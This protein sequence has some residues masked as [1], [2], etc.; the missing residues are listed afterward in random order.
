MT[1]RKKE[2]QRIVEDNYALAKRLSEST[3]GVS[4]KRFDDEWQNTTKYMNSISKRNIRK[5]PKL[6]EL[7]KFMHSVPSSDIGSKKVISLKSPAPETYK[8][9][10][11]P[12]FNSS[13]PGSVLEVANEDKD[14]PKASQGLLKKE[15]VHGN[16]GKGVNEKDFSEIKFQNKI[17]EKDKS[18][19]KSG[20]KDEEEKN[21]RSFN[22]RNQDSRLRPEKSSEKVEGFHEISENERNYQL[23]E[24]KGKKS[25]NKL[26]QIEKSQEINLKKHDEDEKQKEGEGKDIKINE[27]NEEDKGEHEK[28][29]AKIEKTEGKHNKKE[30]KG[31]DIHE[32]SKENIKEI[33]LDNEENSLEPVIEVQKPPE[34]VI[35]DDPPENSELPEAELSVVP[36]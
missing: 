4:F 10:F 31:E 35:S 25:E 21:G 29:V 9:S 1:S 6:E 22:G 26:Q 5:L 18:F 2:A 34:A 20:M 13:L 24:K 23:E 27:G 7:N 8:N 16:Q 3:R 17:E 30:E 12:N 15:L 19:G 32:E 14:T 36:S 33:N 11:S 28:K